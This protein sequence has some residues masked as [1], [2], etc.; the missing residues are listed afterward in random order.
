LIQWQ[1]PNLKT[2]VKNFRKHLIEIP[3]TNKK[4]FPFLIAGSILF[5]GQWTISFILKY[6][7]GSAALGNFD[8][9]LKIAYLLMIPLTAASVIAAPIFSKRFSDAKEENLKS[10]LK[11]ITNGVFLITLPLSLIIFYFSSELMALYGPEFV[12]SGNI[13]KIIVVGIFFNAITGPIAIF[14]QMTENQ[15]TVQNVFFI[16]TL[17]NIALAFFLIPIY[18]I[19]GAAWA[20]LIFQIFVN[21][22]LLYYV[23][24][25]FGYLSFGV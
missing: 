18:G 5:I 6:F 23:Y 7:E 3:K 16:A 8:A 25:K 14:L 24:R 1:F 21:G 13:L 4:S 17:L 10:I 19:E 11:F 9:A 15:S 20:N 12:E 22:V 2:I